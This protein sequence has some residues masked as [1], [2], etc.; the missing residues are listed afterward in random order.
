MSSLDL[1][2]PALPPHND[3]AVV[4]E[5]EGVLQ[6][7]DIQVDGDVHI[8]GTKEEKKLVRKIDLYLMPAIWVLYVFSYVVPMFPLPMY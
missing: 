5:L 2:I 8:E 6:S 7:S 3:K 1:P 4:T